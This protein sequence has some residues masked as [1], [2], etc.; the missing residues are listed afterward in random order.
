MKKITKIILT[1]IITLFM[2]M[3]LKAQIFID[4]DE[5][6]GRMRKGFVDFNLVVPIQGQ[7][8]DQY[9]PLGDGW[10]LL[11]AMGTAYLLRRGR[12]KKED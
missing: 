9:V 6:E 11:T 4:D 7:D 2:A 8:A 3:P 10:L 1:V 12:K 5:F